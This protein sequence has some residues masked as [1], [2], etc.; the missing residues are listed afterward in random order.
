MNMSYNQKNPNNILEKNN[1]ISEA[2]NSLYLRKSKDFKTIR[3]SD[4]NF[5]KIKG[6]IVC[7]IDAIIFYFFI[8][9]LFS[10]Y[11]CIELLWICGM[12]GNS[13]IMDNSRGL[14]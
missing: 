2:L 11:F 13:S 14:Q 12:P 6:S 7:L 3:D 4:I 1:L 8:Y 9:F 5:Q 10:F